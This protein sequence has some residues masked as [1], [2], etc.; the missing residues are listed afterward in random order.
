MRSPPALPDRC[1]STQ[2]GKV[3][4][5]RT[6]MK[7]QEQQGMFKTCL[8]LVEGKAGNAAGMSA[9]AL[10]KADAIFQHSQPRE[11]LEKRL[12]QG[13]LIIQIFKGLIEASPRPEIARHR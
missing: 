1:L 5:V 11:F 3:I 12:F 4:L 10:A 8:E 2:T 7:R 9:V 6:L 13:I